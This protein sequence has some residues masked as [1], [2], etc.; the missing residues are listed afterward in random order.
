MLVLQELVHFNL[1][2]IIYSLPYSVLR[3]RKLPGAGE[4]FGHRN[5]LS[6]ESVRVPDESQESFRRLRS[7][8][9]QCSTWQRVQSFLLF[10]SAALPL[11]LAAIASGKWP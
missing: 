10:G 2:H 11:C 9:G 4:G 6:G 7:G 8:P 5:C 1:T 3:F